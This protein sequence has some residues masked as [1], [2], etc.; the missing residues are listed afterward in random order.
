VIGSSYFGFG[1]HQDPELYLLAV[2]DAKQN[3]DH[4]PLGH[5]PTAL[6]FETVVQN[7]TGFQVSIRKGPDS[8]MIELNSFENFGQP[9]QIHPHAEIDI[10]T[11]CNESGER[12]VRCYCFEKPNHLEFCLS[13]LKEVCKLAGPQCLFST[14]G[15][16]FVVFSEDSDIAATI[17]KL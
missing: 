9:M 15:G 11:H 7:L 4:L 6:E 10:D 14:S 16:E 3:L 8:T 13:I 17:A 5:T 1:L 12:G 2:R